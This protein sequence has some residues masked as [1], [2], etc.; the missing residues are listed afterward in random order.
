MQKVPSQITRL[1]AVGAIAAVALAGCGGGSGAP[2]TSKRC[3]KHPQWKI[4]KGQSSST[5]AP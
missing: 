1:L 2:E 5:T 4:C 3:I